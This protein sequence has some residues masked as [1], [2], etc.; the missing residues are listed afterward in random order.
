MVGRLC[1]AVPQAK[2]IPQLDVRGGDG[3]ATAAV[4]GPVACG[5]A[6][7]PG[8]GDSP[9]SPAGDAHG[10]EGDYMPRSHTFQQHVAQRAP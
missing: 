6:V 8:P 5:E 3:E 4:S 7:Q 1:S 2:E 9:A 10:D